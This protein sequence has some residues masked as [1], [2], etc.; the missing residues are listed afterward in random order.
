LP[1]VRSPGSGQGAGEG[2][3][4]GPIGAGEGSSAAPGGARLAPLRRFLATEAGG[5]AV[6]LAATLAALIWANSPLSDTYDEVWAT[7]FAISLGDLELRHDLRRW[8]NDGLMSLFFLLI[9]LEVR[10]EFDMGEF[11]ERRRVAVPVVAAAAGMLL[12]VLVFLAFNPAGEAARGWALVM[13]TDTAFAIGVLAIAGRRC[14]L[15]LRSFLLTLV[16]VDDIAAVVV[17]AV[18]YSSGLDLVALAVAVGL[19]AGMAV[20][21]ASGVQR[22]GVFALLMVGIWLA[23][24]SS[25]VHPGVAGVMIGLLTSAYPPSRESLEAATGLTRAFRERPTAA[26]A[27][28]AARRITMSLSPNDQ[29]QHALHPWTSFVVVPLFALANAGLDLRGGLLEEALRTP[30]VPGIVLG[31]VAGKSIGIMAGSWLATRPSLGGPPLSVTWPSLIAASSVGGIGFT[32]SLLIAELSYAGP[33]LDHAKVGI[34][35]ASLAAATLGLGLFRV[36]AA[37][38]AEWIR[39]SEARVAPPVPDLR[40]PVDPARDH[41]RGPL[42][43][44]VTLVEYGDF[45]C[46]WCR[47]AA[48]HIRAILEQ[49]EGRIRFVFR[50][51]PL[52]DVHANAALAAEAAE[53]AGAQEAF[54][55][56]HDLLFERQEALG[57]PDLV[58]YA[59]ELGLD[60]SRF[61]ADLRSGRF[62]GRVSR[63]V[64]SAAESGVAGTP[65]YF[66]DDVRYHGSLDPAVIAAELASAAHR[67]P[68]RAPAPAAETPG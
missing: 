40:V 4:P 58:R 16:I 3:G 55:E 67:R 32:M 29:L 23:T 34:F 42:D 36:L 28:R 50:H 21:R 9:G 66:I 7:P 57:L 62:S 10:R 13:T 1:V 49:H 52:T 47:R 20:L 54:W 24:E 33:L 64:N 19:L 30:L 48:P 43:A 18:A 46:P 51:L 15:R 31:L 60:Q 61:E 37:V 65:T 44:P 35:A 8:V 53:A 56:M 2:S 14:P 25:G 63:D 17:I 26:L 22:T 6:L 39:R 27:R 5:A 59:G 68:V 41:V 45:E 12:P 38:P 11:R